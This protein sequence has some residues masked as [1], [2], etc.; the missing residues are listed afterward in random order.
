MG[1]RAVGAR[2]PFQ[3]PEGALGRL[4]RGMVKAATGSQLGPR[5]GGSASR[6]ASRGGLIQ[7]RPGL[8]CILTMLARPA[9]PG[10]GPGSGPARGTAPE[11]GASGPGSSAG[12]PRRGRSTGQVARP[13]RV[14]LASS[15]YRL[16]PTRS[17]GNCHAGSGPRVAA[18]V[19]G[20]GHWPAGGHKW[21]GPALDMVRW[22]Q[23][24]G[25]STRL[26]AHILRRFISG[27]R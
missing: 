3:E 6:R 16:P 19:A 21:A 9:A 8:S 18:A 7:G 12:T 11:E 2:A 25:P 22:A 23:A 26:V 5:Q 15:C 27:G 1:G 13:S 20:G 17:R 14:R 4:G 10:G 24:D